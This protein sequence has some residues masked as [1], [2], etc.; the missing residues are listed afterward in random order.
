MAGDVEVD[1]GSGYTGALQQ[2]LQGELSFADYRSL[3][4]LLEHFRMVCRLPKHTMLG[5]YGPHSASGESAS[6]PTT[7]VA[8]SQIIT[9]QLIF[10]QEALNK[11]SGAA[12]TAALRRPHL[13]LRAPPSA[14]RLVFSI[15]S[16]AAADSASDACGGAGGMAAGSAG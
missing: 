3:I 12:V 16:D 1:G 5:L 2:A 11:T 7:L 13:P 6:G 15:F 4:G 9:D 10:W 8:P 14:P